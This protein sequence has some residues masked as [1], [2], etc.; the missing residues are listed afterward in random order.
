MDTQ[1]L[2]ALCIAVQAVYTHERA[3]PVY[4]SASSSALLTTASQARQRSTRGDPILAIGYWLL[5]IRVA[6]SLACD[7]GLPLQKIERAL[8]FLR[9][10]TDRT[11]PILH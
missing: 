4:W 10:D 2:S 9:K 3:K 1:L 5:A 6:I 8:K 7:R 11:Q